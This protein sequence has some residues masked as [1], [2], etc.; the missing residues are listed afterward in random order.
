[1]K[2]QQSLTIAL[3]IHIRMFSVIFVLHSY[4]NYFQNI[5]NRIVN[6]GYLKFFCFI[7]F[8]QKIIIVT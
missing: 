2:S 7:Y 8:T 1:M 6:T 5:W 3:I 4:Y